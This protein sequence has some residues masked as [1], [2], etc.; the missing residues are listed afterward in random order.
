MDLQLTLRLY[1]VYP[2]RETKHSGNRRVNTKMGDI[3]SRLAVLTLSSSGRHSYG[4]DEVD[5]KLVF[6][7]CL[8]SAD[9]CYLPVRRKCEAEVPC[10][11]RA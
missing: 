1:Y 7:V 11:R 6:H 5:N 9:M 8:D 2:V 10:D 4:K 3:S